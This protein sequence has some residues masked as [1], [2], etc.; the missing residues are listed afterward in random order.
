MLMKH[1]WLSFFCVADCWWGWQS[2]MLDRRQWAGYRQLDEVRTERPDI[3]RAEHGSC[4]DWEHGRSTTTAT[5]HYCDHWSCDHWSCDHWSSADP[6]DLFA[7]IIIIIIFLIFFGGDIEF[8]KSMTDITWMKINNV[9]KWIDHTLRN[10][11]SNFYDT[12]TVINHSL[13]QISNLPF[14]SKPKKGIKKKQC[15]QKW[16][17]PAVVTHNGVSNKLRLGVTQYRSI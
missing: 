13:F 10:Q 7:N 2:Q 14:T 16:L 15:T 6:F 8:L 5:S 11:P 9:V 3:W 4:A 17:S 1:F 12:S